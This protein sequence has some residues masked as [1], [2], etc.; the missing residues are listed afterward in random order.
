MLSLRIDDFHASM[1]CAGF[2]WFGI[3]PTATYNRDRLDRQLRY[4]G[5]SKR[6]LVAGSRVSGVMQWKKNSLPN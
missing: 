4:A 3:Q 2:C 6:G 1:K 5:W